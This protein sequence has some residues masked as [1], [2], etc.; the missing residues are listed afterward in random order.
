MNQDDGSLRPRSVVISGAGALVLCYLGLRWWSSR[1]HTLPQNSWVGIALIVLI[2][3]VLL[4][5]AWQVRSFVRDPKAS[6]RPPSPQFS[7]GV[8]VGARAGAVA[9]ALAAGWY[10]AQALVR[11]PNADI[12]S[13]RS[14]LFLAALLA[15]AAAGLAVAGLVAQSWCRLPPEDDDGRESERG[16]AAT[17]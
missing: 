10:L 12:D 6:R 11:L 3:V 14:A 13:Q 1:G 15:L 4:F 2:A 8:L 9:G 5:C 17:A 16:G 7:R